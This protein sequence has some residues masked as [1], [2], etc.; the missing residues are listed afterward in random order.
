MIRSR[1]HPVRFYLILFAGFIFFCGVGILPI[2]VSLFSSISPKSQLGSLFL[3]ALGASSTSLSAYFLWKFPRYAPNIVLDDSAFYFGLERYK[4]AEISNISF[5]QE[6]EFKLF[7]KVTMIGSYIEF[8]DG[9]SRF[10]LNG[11]YSNSAQL[12]YHF[13]RKLVNKEQGSI[14][15]PNNS[16]I[17]PIHETKAR[18]YKGDPILSFRGILLWATL[19]L[20]L[21]FALTE[22]LSIEE[23]I[24]WIIGWGGE[25]IF[26]S[27]TMYYAVLSE[28][29]LVLKNHARIWKSRTYRTSDIKE[30]VFERHKQLGYRVRIATK[31]HRTKVFSAS[32]LTESTWR[33]LQAHLKELD[34]PVKDKIGLSLL[35]KL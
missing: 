28:D 33:K 29:F 12:N 6:L 5:D 16:E 20:I 25:L 34:I 8:I 3:V 32:T 26:F 30:V 11:M 31:D 10:I 23:M 17:T 9:S 4:W 21:I 27:W 35:P 18:V 19:V 2:W 24:P 13:G 7:T 14:R 22:K 1:R 15:I